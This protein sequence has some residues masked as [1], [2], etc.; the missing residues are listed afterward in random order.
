M[1]LESLSSFKNWKGCGKQIKTHVIRAW[2]CFN[3]EKAT[4]QFCISF[5]KYDNEDIGF[6]IS[7][8]VEDAKLLVKE[9]NRALGGL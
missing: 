6:G 9:I 2:P 8:S 4:D 7:C 3:E 1:S 5:G